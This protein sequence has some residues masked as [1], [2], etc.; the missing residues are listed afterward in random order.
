MA[1]FVEM[2]L[3]AKM[4]S[5]WAVAAWDS[6]AEINLG[7]AV[8]QVMTIQ[9]IVAVATPFNGTAP[10]LSI[11]TDA[12]HEALMPAVDL[13]APDYQ[14]YARLLLRLVDTPTQFVVF[15]DAGSS[16]AGEARVLLTHA[17]AA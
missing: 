9:I 13:T 11:G 8:G 6:A 7:A 4:S 16:T 10:T 15:L 12:D 14:Q 2:G 3:A 17:A 5:N 1:G